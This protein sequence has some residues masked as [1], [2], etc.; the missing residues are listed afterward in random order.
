M[1]SE[2]RVLSLRN[3]SHFPG[4]HTPLLDFINIRKILDK[5][6][7]R[8][9]KIPITLGPGWIWIVRHRK[10]Q[11]RSGRY[12]SLYL[13]KKLFKYYTYLSFISFLKTIRYSHLRA[14]RDVTSPLTT[15]LSYKN[16]R[17]I[18]FL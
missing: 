1:R 6:K 16:R 7:P 2:H 15:N 17:F 4:S 18:R 14:N 11:T 3:L 8:R 13:F 5:K 12:K 10:Q 9:R